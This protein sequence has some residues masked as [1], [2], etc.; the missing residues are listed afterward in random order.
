LLVE[1]VDVRVAAV[2]EHATHSLQVTEI[3]GVASGDATAIRGCE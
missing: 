1:R 2:G 3:G